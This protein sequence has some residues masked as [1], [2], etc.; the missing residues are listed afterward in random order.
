MIAD[1]ASVT[2]GGT[3][4]SLAKINQD[5]YGSTYRL[6]LTDRDITMTV[7]NTSRNE[8][9][10]KIIDRHNIELTETVFPVAPAVLSTVRKVYVVVENQQG[11][12]LADPINVAAALFA[13]LTASTNANLLKLLNFES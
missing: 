9:S 4:R 13:F 8:K 11:D 1:P 6:R 7:R 5:D 10:G 3:A 12:T 2:I